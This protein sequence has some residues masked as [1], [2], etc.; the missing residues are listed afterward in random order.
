MVWLGQQ[1]VL[2]DQS[3]PLTKEE[4]KNHCHAGYDDVD[5]IVPS[6]SCQDRKGMAFAALQS[7]PPTS[8]CV[9]NKQLGYLRTE[10]REFDAGE[11]YACNPEGAMLVGYQL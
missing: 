3:C 5:V 6:A 11:E 4:E 9:G 10:C 2:K 1:V 8:R 7:L